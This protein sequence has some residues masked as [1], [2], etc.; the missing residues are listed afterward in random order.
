MS[1]DRDLQEETA[2][3]FVEPRAGQ[4]APTKILETEK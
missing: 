3:S 1:E 4:K 2:T